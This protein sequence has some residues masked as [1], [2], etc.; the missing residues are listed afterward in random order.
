M[1]A[2][3]IGLSDLLASV[4]RCRDLATALM[5]GALCVYPTETIYGVGGRAGGEA[6]ERVAAALCRAKGRAPDNPMI[7]IAEARARFDTLGLCWTEMALRLADAVWPG[8]LTLVLDCHGGGTCAVRVSAHPFL[9]AVGRW[10]EV[11]LYST[12][13]NMSAAPYCPNPDHIYT[14]FRST[15]DFMIDAGELA[16]SP[17]STIVA[18]PRQGEP[19]CLRE[20]AL[21][22][23]GL[24]LLLG[25][26]EEV[27]RR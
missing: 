5:Q 10:I 9:C 25:K 7:I 20:G 18:C 16:P 1:P 8:N 22:W 26:G 2:E 14:V 15:V 6:G 12:S 21:S 4:D 24:C 17:P 23:E 27:Q 19:L 3:R 13:A 11:P